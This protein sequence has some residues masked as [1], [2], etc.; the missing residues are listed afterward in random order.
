MVPLMMNQLKVA[1]SAVREA[2]EYVKQIMV[3]RGAIDEKIGEH[4]ASYSFS[5]I[6]VIERN[7]MRLAVFEMLH[8][9]STPEKVSISE[10][11][12]LARKFATP[13]SANFI[14][15]VL[16]NIYKSTQGVQPESDDI[17]KSIEALTKSEEA[18]HDAAKATPPTIESEGDLFS[19]E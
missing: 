8:D 14:N 12:R 15:A 3:N 4:S 6:Q 19:E 17:T 16:D 2:Q 7:I 9:P 10:A 13:E 18:A 5:R 1:K 11:I